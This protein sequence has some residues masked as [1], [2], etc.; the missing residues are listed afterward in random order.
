MAQVY[1]ML[2][3]EF[4]KQSALDPLLRSKYATFV[5]SQDCLTESLLEDVALKLR[6]AR[7]EIDTQNHM[8]GKQAKSLPWN[9]V[10][11]L[12]VDVAR[13][14]P[15]TLNLRT[16]A[17][18]K[19]YIVTHGVPHILHQYYESSKNKALW[20]NEDNMHIGLAGTNY[21]PGPSMPDPHPNITGAVDKIRDAVDLGHGL[22]SGISGDDV[23]NTRIAADSVGRIEAMR[24]SFTFNQAAPTHF[25]Q[26][27]K[28][29]QQMNMNSY[30]Y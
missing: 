14:N 16:H 9:A 10:Y 19:D 18:V 1:D 13:T 24:R 5:F 6:D 2:H 30:V 17:Q 8:Y 12:L 11:D 25:A 27:V 20:A 28:F 26:P 4:E 22:D 7:Y 15:A 23:N 29:K 21:R 3:A